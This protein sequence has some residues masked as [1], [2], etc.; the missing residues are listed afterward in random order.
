MENIIM[1]YSVIDYYMNAHDFLP[2]DR[3]KIYDFINTENRIR[4]GNHKITGGYLTRTKLHLI[5]GDGVPEEYDRE[6]LG[7]QD[8]F[9]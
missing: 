9:K 8:N 2:C 3:K 7:I 6:W 5:T 1:N 4:N